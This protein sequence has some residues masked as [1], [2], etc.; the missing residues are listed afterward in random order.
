MSGQVQIKK[1]DQESLYDYHSEK[2]LKQADLYYMQKKFALKT[3]YDELRTIHS[4]LLQDALCDD[5][6]E[7]VNFIYKKLT[8]Q[9][10]K[11]RKKKKQ[12]TSKLIEEDN[13][14][15]I[16]NYYATEQLEWTDGVQW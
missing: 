16:N 12:K 9:L 14:I 5:D 13:N 15:I 1:Y 3:E 8:G 7:I 11:T 6:C 2:L 10:E 4:Y